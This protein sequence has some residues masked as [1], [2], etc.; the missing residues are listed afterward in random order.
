MLSSRQWQ[1]PHPSFATPAATLFLFDRSHSLH[2]WAVRS[3][4]DQRPLTEME[5]FDFAVRSILLPKV[6]QFMMPVSTQEGDNL[7]YA[8]RFIIPKLSSNLLTHSLRSLEVDVFRLILDHFGLNSDGYQYVLEAF[9]DMLSIGAKDFWDAMGAIAPTTVVE[10]IFHNDQYTKILAQ[11]REE[12]DFSTSTLGIMMN[13]VKPFMV[14]LSA[15]AQASACRALCSQYL[16]KLPQAGIPLHAQRECLLQGLAVLNQTL[17]TCNKVERST[18][19][20]GRAVAAEVVAEV[21]TRVDKLLSLPRLAARNEKFARTAQLAVK[22]VSL[23][24]ALECKCLKTDQDTLRNVDEMA[25][26]Y[27]SYSPKL[28]D[29]VVR[30]LDR[31]NVELAKT[32]LKSINNLTGLEKFK[33]KPDEMNERAKNEYNL[34]FGRLTHLV[35]QI[36][37]RVGD[38]DP[39]DLDKLYRQPESAY[40]LVATLFS[41]DD[42]TYQASLSVAKTL[43][44]ESTRRDAIRHILTQDFLS[45]T[46]GALSWSNNRLTQNKTFAACPRMIKTCGDVVDAL[47]NPDDGLLRVPTLQGR[48]GS[49]ALSSFWTNQWAVL[50]MIYQSTERWS[51]EKVAV[52]ETMKQFCRDVMEFSDRLFEQYGVFSGAIRMIEEVKKEDGLSELKDLLSEPTRTLLNM[53]KWL[54]LR[55]PFL[56]QTA[57]R[58]TKRIIDQLSEEHKP[59][60][61]EVENYLGSI[62]VETVKTQLSKQELAE[63]ER[64]L[65]TN[66][67][68]PLTRETPQDDSRSSSMDRRRVQ[69]RKPRFK[70]GMIDLEK[71]K[72]KAGSTP[73][74]ID[75]SEEDEYGGSKEFDEDIMAASRSVE[76]M[77]KSSLAQNTSKDVKKPL[78]HTSKKVEPI[79]AKP[80]IQSKAAQASF[81]NNRKKDLE[82]KRRQKEALRK[83]PR[84]G[85]ELIPGEGTAVSG[86]GLSGKDHAP[87]K[88]EG[89]MVSSGSESESEDDIDENLF[90]PTNG[91][92]TNGM[93]GRRRNIQ[94][95]HAQLPVKK[96]K[97]VRSVKDM[98]ARLAPDLSQLHRSILSWEF[99]HEG[100]FPPGS[101]SHDYTLVSNTFRSPVDYHKTFEP[102][103]ILEAWQGFLKSKEEGTSKSFE[104]KVAN[105]LSVDA[106]VEVSI[107][108]PHADSKEV[109]I[110]EAD[111]VLMSKAKNPASDASQPHCLAR[112]FKV[113]RKKASVDVSY[114]LMSANPLIN[115]LVPNATL[116]ATKIL[117]MTPLEREY[118]ALLGLTYFDLCDEV[119]RAKPSPLLTYTEKQLDPIVM[120]Y[121]LNKAQSQAVRSAMDNDGFTLIQGPPGSGKT[122]TIVAIVGAVLTGSFSE[123][124]VPISRPKDPNASRSSTI[125]SKKLLVCAP[126][127]A[128]VDELVMRF[129]KGVQTTDG[130]IRKPSVVRLGR[131]DAI[132]ANVMDV[133]LEELVNARM[134]PKSVR[135]EAGDELHNVMQQHKA[136][137][138]EFNA[139][140]DQVDKQKA[141]GKSATPEQDRQFEVLKRQK[142]QLGNKIDETRD[143]GNTA[144]RDLEINRRKIEQDILDGAH[145]ICATLSG[146]GNERFQNLNI[147]FETVIIDEA[148]QSIELSALIPLKYGCSKCILVGDPKQL[149][150]TVLSREAARFQYEQSLFVRMQMNHPQSV[151]LLDTQYRMHP[152]ISSFPSRMFYDAKLLDGPDMA[153]LRKQPWHES[154]ILSP[155]RF[156][157]VRGAHQSAPKGH[158]LINLAEIDVALHLFNRLI[159]DFRGYDFNGKVGIIT[160]YKSQLRELRSR[161][162]QRYGEQI[163]TSVAFNTTDAFQGRETEIIIFSCVRA[164]NSKG[165]GFLSDIRRMN[166]G[167]TRAKSSLWVLGNSQSLMQGEFW[168]KLIEDAKARRCYSDGDLPSM[169]RRPFTEFRAR[170]I[171]EVAQDNDVEM[172][173]A[174]SLDGGLQPPA[175]ESTAKG[176]PPLKSGGNNG[177]DP[178][179]ACAACGSTDHMTKA[180]T[181]S[182]ARLVAGL[183]CSRCKSSKHQTRFCPVVRCTLCGTYGHI[184]GNCPSA[185]ALPEAEK[186]QVFREEKSHER[187][188]ANQVDNQRKKQLGEHDREVPK[189][190][191]TRS[192]SP[193]SGQG[194]GKRK[195]DDLDRR[196]STNGPIKAPKG[197]RVEHP[198]GRSRGDRPFVNSDTLRGSEISGINGTTDLPLRSPDASTMNGPKIGR[199]PFTMTDEHG[200]AH[201]LTNVSSHNRRDEDVK[202]DGAP[203]GTKLI[204]KKKKDPTA[205]MF[206]PKRR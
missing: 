33:I 147:E 183:D 172:A 61:S 179:K 40:A 30:Q 200:G 46:L 57:V 66:T 97:Q 80:Q 198:L 121:A 156:F 76:L 169:L 47:C 55:D 102:L 114:R 123:E 190:R 100:D 39:D 204:R 38:F 12:D 83:A 45:T 115:A 158:S 52:G 29:V 73:T 31:G 41:A 186:D 96:K 187:R 138:E 35:C 51:I 171:T 22:A 149:P 116:Y 122:K 140:R 74:P 163:L 125:A 117:S 86:L 75:L 132:N 196:N 4:Q 6:N 88:G 56:A 23:A 104:I 205:A 107:T 70:A 189:I 59:L 175:T 165:I 64:A 109:G 143:T 44:L 128:A 135:K 180:C 137:C 206:M 112:V 195:R 42:S 93:D 69:N 119:I 108:M 178:T 89:I 177:L 126:S 19:A 28:W 146:S 36:L 87:A 68:R 71:W 67:G 84:K 15:E 14:S 127:N 150:P 141:A 79:A 192:P 174:P 154:E 148:A 50:N 142:Q 81:L 167:I 185:K 7:W 105:R 32:V 194:S 181:N 95:P 94:G 201:G 98:R 11:S 155:Y 124:S 160:P 3:W 13:W 34:T 8:L 130:A 101:K 202:P 37:E 82:E 120:S 159:A 90:G 111:V 21:T 191:T 203:A 118:G 2:Q 62:I 85:G 173:D 152:E 162:A 53:T 134:D 72:S 170:S 77:K 188:R 184:A 1:A 92:K 129:K 131:S 199:D 27:S 16:E 99:F 106:F 48:Q 9:T 164:S 24:L 63:L 20:N 60:P 54:R 161:F 65:E 168:G 139:L 25:M 136:V 151:H 91:V 133:T 193:G 145:I 113:T 176:Y 18:S 197:P 43:S 182:E 166:V 157:D 78:A 49:E 5:D 153:G 58:L 26:I 110:S 103:L 17:A 144:A 10:T